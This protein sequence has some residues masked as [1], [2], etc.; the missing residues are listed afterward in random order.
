LSLGIIDMNF[1]WCILIGL[2]LGAIS[3]LLAPRRSPGSIIVRMLIGATGAILTAIIFPPASNS[4]W[5]S[6][7]GGVFLV[8]IYFLL[9]GK[10]KTT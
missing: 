7:I 2:A 6:A 5:P 1:L 10:R 9:V 8:V 3:G 4:I